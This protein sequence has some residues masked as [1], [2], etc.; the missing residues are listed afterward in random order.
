MTDVLE[1]LRRELGDAVRSDP[2]T[3]AALSRDAWVMAALDTCENGP[4]AL[5]LAVVEPTSTAAVS[6]ALALCR[7]LGVPVVPIGA[8]SGVC[9]AQ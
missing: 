8:G 9:G 6:Q 7:S 2:E 1:I 3:R 4:R 5:P